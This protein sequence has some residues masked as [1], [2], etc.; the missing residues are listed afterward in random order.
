MLLL[1]FGIFELAKQYK[2][3]RVMSQISMLFSESGFTFSYSNFGKEKLNV[4]V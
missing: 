2:R 4:T 3:L 1:R